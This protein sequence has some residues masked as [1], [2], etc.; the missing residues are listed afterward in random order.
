M[1]YTE[2][3]KIAGGS[4]SAYGAHRFSQVIKLRTE[5]VKDFLLFSE[6][7]AEDCAK[8]VAAAQERVY[9]CGK[10]IYFEG[11]PVRQVVLVTSGCVKLSQTGPQGQEVILRLVGPGETLCAECFPKYSHCSTARTM[12]PSAALVWEVSQFEAVA[13]RFPALGRNVSGVLLHTLNQ[14]EIRFREMC[15]EKVGPRLSS[16][17]VRLVSQ[18]GQPTNG[19]VEISLSQRDLAQLT[20]T[21]LFTVSRLLGQWEELGIVRPKRQGLLVLNVQA[22]EDI[23]RAE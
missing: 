14:L 11:D 20:G 13:D 16:Q 21:T 6:I 4:A 10:T 3:N 15:T 18:V 8:I 22:L 9:Q 7:P 19:Y 2:A 1:E 5:L 12:K 23:S 17:L